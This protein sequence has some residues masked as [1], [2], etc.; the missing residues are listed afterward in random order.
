MPQH[1]SLQPSAFSIFPVKPSQGKSSFAPTELSCI[2]P[3]SRFKAHRFHPVNPVHPVS[4]LANSALCTCN[5]PLVRP[6]PT[7]S[8]QVA[9]GQTGFFVFLRGN[10]SVSVCVHLWLAVHIPSIPVRI[11]SKQ[12][13]NQVQASQTAFPAMPKDFILQILSILSPPLGF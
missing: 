8:H 7:Q 9:L 11:L 1:F 6:S 12:K 10:S 5:L 2:S 4:A 3:G 13:S